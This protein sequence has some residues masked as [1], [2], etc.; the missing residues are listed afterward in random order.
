M[1]SESHLLSVRLGLGRLA[2]LAMPTQVHRDDPMVLGE[3]RD[4][5]RSNPSRINVIPLAVQQD[6]RLPFPLFDIAD[7]H[8]ISI[9]PRPPQ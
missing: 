1:T 8:T 6:E 5:T 9:D 7:S 4:H 3:V 2:A